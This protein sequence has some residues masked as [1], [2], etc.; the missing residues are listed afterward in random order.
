MSAASTKLLFWLKRQVTGTL[1]F[2]T[3]IGA[4]ATSDGSDS[5][6]TNTPTGVP[7][8]VCTEEDVGTVSRSQT[9]P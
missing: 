9:K 5:I 4:K 7:K 3:E 6:A 2:G 1:D 8:L